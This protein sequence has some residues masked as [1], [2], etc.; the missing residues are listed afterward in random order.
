MRFGVILSG[1]GVKDGS[2]IHEATMMLLSIVSRGHR[3]HCLA[4]DGPQAQVVDHLTGSVHAESRQM[5]AESARIARGEIT[6]LAQAKLDDYDAIVLPG[7]FGAAINLCDFANRGAHCTVH[8]ELE[9]FL[10]SAQKAG[11][12]LGFICI[13]PVIAA[14]LFGSKGVQMTIGNDPETAKK[15]TQMG[16]VHVNCAYN[17]ACVD[18]KLKIASS[19]AYML[20]KTIAECHESAD[21]LIAAVEA[22]AKA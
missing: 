21:A 4:I 2:E 22:L 13:A 12:P 20:A 16:A 10:E 7:G 9:A 15:C 8:P 19:P 17:E 5:L 1:C 6:A 14:R 18:D 3:Y 11:K